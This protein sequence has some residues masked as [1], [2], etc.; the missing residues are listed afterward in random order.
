MGL[1]IKLGFIPT[2][3]FPVSGARSPFPVLVT[4]DFKNSY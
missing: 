1:G 4:S 3:H 2:F